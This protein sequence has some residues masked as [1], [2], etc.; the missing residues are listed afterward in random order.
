MLI[1]SILA[2]IL[3]TCV[4]S[5]VMSEYES[6]L[7]FASAFSFVVFGTLFLISV[8]SIPAERMEDHATIRQYQITKETLESAREGNEK[9]ENA[10]L[11]HKVI[12]I[13]QKIASIKYW[14]STLFDLWH[15]DE[16]ED[17]EPLR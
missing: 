2:L 9:L 1:L 5:F 14:N 12:E 16:V 6:V 7:K 4:V 8:I 15:P 13:N 17:L 10:A 11:Q 3:M